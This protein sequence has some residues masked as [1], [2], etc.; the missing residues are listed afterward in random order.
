MPSRSQDDAGIV[1]PLRSFMLGKARLATALSATAREALAR[2]MAECVVNAAGA[3]PVVV[4]SSAPDAVAWARNLDLAIVDDPGSLNGAASAGRAW[5]IERGLARYASVHGDLPLANSLD[6]VVGDGDGAVAV[7]VPDHRDD[8]TPVLSLP[9][10]FPFTFAYGPGSAARHVA[11]AA[12]RSLA[13]R[14]VR[15]SALGFDVDIEAD[16]AALEALRHPPP[17]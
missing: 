4:T 14:I 2:S 7:I 1:V 6:N 16:L 17:R 10:A 11:E 15:D 12:Q 5:A 3:R 13:V 9:S 8:G